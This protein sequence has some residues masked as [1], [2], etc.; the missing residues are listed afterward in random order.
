MRHI[1]LAILLSALP[2]AAAPAL[3]QTPPSQPPAAQPAA[4]PADLCRE[5]LAYAEKSAAEPRSPDGQAAKSS[6]GADADTGKQGGGSADSRSSSS[7]SSQESAPATEPTSPG[8]APEAATS[9]HATDGDKPAGGTLAGGYTIEAVRDTAA[10][11]D[12]GACRDTAQKM[13]RAGGD[14][15]APLMALA[16]YEPDPAKRQ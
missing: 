11:G 1:S 3:A 15:P 14:L 2:L 8:A 4:G 6:R 7:T 13:R 5:L 16:A 12:R 10:A 9:P